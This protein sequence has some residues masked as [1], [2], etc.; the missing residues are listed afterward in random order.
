MQQGLQTPNIRSLSSAIRNQYVPEGI[1]GIN[2]HERLD[3]K[4][5]VVICSRD[6]LPCVNCLLSCP[7]FAKNMYN[8]FRLVKD[9][10]G[11]PRRIIGAYNIGDWFE[12]I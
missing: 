4:Q 8:R 9:R 11:V 2:F 5:N 7:Q 6:L 3:C 10:N 1:K 12:H